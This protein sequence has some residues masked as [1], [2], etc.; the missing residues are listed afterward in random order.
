MQESLEERCVSLVRTEPFYVYGTGYVAHRLY[1]GLLHHGGIE[2][3]QGF[4]VTTCAEGDARE[5]F[6]KPVQPIAELPR[7]ALILIAVHMV[8]KDEIEETLKRLGFHRYAFIYARLFEFQFGA[9]VVRHQKMECSRLVEHLC[10]R[11]EAYYFLAAYIAAI[12][13]LFH[14]DE[15][16][17]AYYLKFHA[18]C[19]SPEAARKRLERFH[20][21]L[22][23]C[24]ANGAE[25]LL[26]DPISLDEQQR[27]LDGTHRTAAATWFHVPFLYADQYETDDHWGMGYERGQC[28]FSHDEVFTADD[29]HALDQEK[30]VFLKG[31]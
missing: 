18:R 7:D 28:G 5:L 6:G 9:P 20:A 22:L 29:L 21:M 14:P 13:H 30:C 17:D 4:T 11:P 3:L 25:A 26:R 12:H 16:S 23:D 8:W 31:M 19:A 2:H 27:I 10:A 24:Q 15:A 1:Q